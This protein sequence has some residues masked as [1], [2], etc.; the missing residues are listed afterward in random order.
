MSFNSFRYTAIVHPLRYTSFV[1][2]PR[3]IIIILFIWL[4]SAVTALVQLSWLDPFHHD[5]TEDP[6]DDIMKAELIYDIVFL[7]LFFLLP[8]VF[9]SFTYSCIIVE[10]TRQS[11]NIQK[12]C[13]RCLEGKRKRKRHER[14]AVAIFAA[15]IFVY[16]I[17]WLPFFGL[18]RFDFFL[19]LPLPLMYV[20]F[21]LRFLASLLNPCMYIMGKQ[22]FR[23]AIFDSQVKLEINLTSVSKP[24]ALRGALATVEGVN[25]LVMMQPLSRVEGRKTSSL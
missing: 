17:C 14:K 10:I 12:Q 9:M 4:F 11:R 19:E 6:T 16:I 3:C 2:R 8:F 1:T 22:D 7:V 23:K 5:P 25:E 21:W 18:R 20:I 13:V 15:M 24:S